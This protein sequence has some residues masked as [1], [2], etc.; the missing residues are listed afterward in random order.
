ME[1]LLARRGYSEDATEGDLFDMS[2]GVQEFLCYTLEDRVRPS[3]HKVYGKTAI[4]AGK[5]RIVVTM[6]PRFREWMPLLRDVPG[7]S[8]I[9]IH[10]GNTAADTEGCI[11]VGD[12]PTTSQDNWLGKS[13]IAYA[14]LRDRIVAAQERGE[15]VW[16]TVHNGPQVNE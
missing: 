10:P 2:E 13:R 5:Y 8:G 4:P 16:I 6:S 9:R 7:F 15:E 12:E 1:L 11:L 3:G 14:R